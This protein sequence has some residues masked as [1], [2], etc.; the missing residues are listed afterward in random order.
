MGY[1]IMVYT[2]HAAITDLFKGKNLH[3]RLARWLLTIQAYNPEI[4]YV[5]GKA[6]VV[7]DVLSRN[8]RI[9][10][11]TNSEVVRNFTS[12]ELHSA[13]R[14]HPVRKKIIYAL[15]SGHETNIPELPVPFAQL[16]LSEDSLLCRS[17]PTK[18]VPV[19]QLVIPDKYAPV[20]LQLVHDTHIAGHP[21]RDKTLS[22]TR[23]KYY[24]PTLRVDVEEYVAQCVVCARHKGS[25]KGPA[26][27][28]QY[29]VPG[30]PWHLV[31]IDLLQLPQS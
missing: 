3:G 7:A 17:W 23:Q 10:A 19:E 26:P 20:T 29:P 9:G 21:G 25:V 24:W 4:K 28:L 6:N 22:V 8:I 5:T 16:F 2:D 1:K 30:A 12:P 31:N 13:Q 11:I 27:M 18:P 15:E 14:E